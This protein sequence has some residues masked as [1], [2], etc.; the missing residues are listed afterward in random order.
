MVCEL[1]LTL[2]KEPG[3]GWPYIVSMQ[4]DITSEV[5]VKRLLAATGSDGDY[6]DLVREQEAKM[7]ASLSAEGIDCS[8]AKCYFDDKVIQCWSEKLGIMDPLTLTDASTA[9]PTDSDIHSRSSDS[10]S[11]D[12]CTAFSQSQA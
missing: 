1:I 3:T 6:A 7:R 10:R 12:Y 4:R 2:H 5:S 8:E 9:E 11:S